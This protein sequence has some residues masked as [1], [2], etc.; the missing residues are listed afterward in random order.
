MSIRRKIT[1]VNTKGLHARPAASFVKLAN[2]FS[3]KIRI[4]YGEKNIDGKSIMGVMMLAAAKGA[5]IEIEA[6]GPDEEKAIESLSSL[7]CNG[8]GEHKETA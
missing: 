7:V 8:F 6:D 4:R 3:S 5:M 2:E 1:I